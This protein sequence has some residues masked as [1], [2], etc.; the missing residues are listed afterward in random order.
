MERHKTQ[1][2]S[3]G[4]DKQGGSGSWDKVIKAN[5]KERHHISIYSILSEVSNNEENTV[6]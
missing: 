1:F 5:Y 2:C 3:L 6:N 4:L